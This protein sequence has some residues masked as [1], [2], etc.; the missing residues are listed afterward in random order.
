MHK[1]QNYGAR[2]IPHVR[3]KN[4]LGNLRNFLLN[5][6]TNRT[7]PYSAQIEIT[8][9]CNAN[10]PFCSVKT[11]PQSYVNHEMTTEQA[12]Y[13]IDQLAGI[14]VK[15]LSITGGEPTLRKDLPELVH[16]MGIEHNFINGITSNGYLLPKVLPKLEGLD[17]ILTSLDYPTAELHNK[18][19]GL[20]VFDKVIESIKIANR[21][22]IKVI[23]ST[24]VMNDNLHLLE[25][26]CE[27]AKSLECPIELYPCEDIIWDISGTTYSV[28][29]IHNIIP[30]VNSWANKIRDLRK[31]Y[32]NILTE[33][34]SISIIEKGGFG[35]NPKHQNIL[36]CHVAETY[37]FVRHDGTIDYPCKI[38]PV[39][40]YNVLNHSLSTIH[41]STEVR[42]IMKVHDNYDFCDGCRLGCAIMSSIPTRLR[43]LYSKYIKGY[44][45]G[46]LR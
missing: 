34:V 24:V 25:D 46:N 5:N 12:K 39:K 20:N 42:E 4:Y 38:H 19:R 30:D 36:R 14:G 35:G 16:Y 22:G 3:I 33:P 29:D 43:T 23:I 2:V 6:F 31:H 1:L 15:S 17:F 21:M 26:I 32:K 7:I 37:M 11:L 44:L 8:L 40:S 45:V 10:C 28:K 41:T 9:R 13:I 27:L 18:A